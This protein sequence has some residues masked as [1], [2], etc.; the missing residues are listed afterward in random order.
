MSESPRIYP[1]KLEVKPLDRPPV[2][3]VR[4]PGSKSITNRALVLAAL[5]EPNGTS[6]RT[7]L[8]GPLRSKDTEIMVTCLR[9]LGIKIIEDWQNSRLEV[10]HVFRSDWA[11]SADFFCGNS[12]TTLRFLTAAVSAGQGCFR[13]DGVSRMRER[14]IQDLL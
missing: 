10:D 5:T 11:R 14:P 4:V 8:N 9:G 2:A 7:V 1:D 12:G 13:L 6:S 3:T